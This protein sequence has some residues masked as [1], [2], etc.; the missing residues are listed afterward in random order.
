MAFTCKQLIF[1]NHV[2]VEEVIRVMRGNNQKGF[3]IL[4]KILTMP[5]LANGSAARDGGLR[6]GLFMDPAQIPPNKKLL[7]DTLTK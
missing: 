2:T 3:S 1:S 6:T 4:K 5:E 7:L